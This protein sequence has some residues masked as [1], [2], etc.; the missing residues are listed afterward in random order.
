[1]VVGWRGSAHRP[2][3]GTGKMETL[4]T[5]DREAALAFFG[6]GARGPLVGTASAGR[7]GTKR[8]AV[9]SEQHL[10]C[11][12]R[13][14][15]SE[16]SE[17]WLGAR[18]V[19]FRQPQAPCSSLLGVPL[20]EEELSEQKRELSCASP[21]EEHDRHSCCAGGVGAGFG[22]QERV[23]NSTCGAMPRA[24]GHLDHRAGER[25]SAPFG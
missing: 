17:T 20:R 22:V 7:H 24:S 23:L 5:A 9:G 18:C 4:T 19:H 15:P 16:T 25:I 11:A 14:S 13:G 2:S 1:M 10:C 3:C 12:K 21:T 6:G 8:Q